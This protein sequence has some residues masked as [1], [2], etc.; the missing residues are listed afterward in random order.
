[1]NVGKYSST[2]DHLGLVDI[3]IAIPPS[4]VQPISG[5]WIA[6]SEPKLPSSFPMQKPCDLRSNCFKTKT[7]TI[8]AWVVYVHVYYMYKKYVISI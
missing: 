7:R 6:H 5:T 3:S 4:L 2:M 8:S 1:M